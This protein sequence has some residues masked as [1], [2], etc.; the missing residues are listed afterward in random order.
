MS[1]RIGLG[2][3][4]GTVRAVVVRHRRIAWA[5]EAPLAGADEL[6]T[7]L[8]GLLALAPVPRWPRP[9]LH[10]AVGPHAAQLKRVV[11]LPEIADPDALAAIVREAAGTY[12]LRNGIPLITTGVQPAGAGSAVAGALERPCVDAIRA[13]CLA[14]GLRLG[15]IVPTAVALTRSLTDASF[16]WTDGRLTIEVQRAGPLIEAVRTRPTVPSDAEPLT[17]T[18]VADLAALGADSQ[19]YADAFGAA[20]LDAHEPVAIRSAAGLTT[21]VAGRRSL[22]QLAAVIAAGIIV[23]GLSPFA[24][25]WAGD[26]AQ[27]HVAQ[28]RPGRWKVITTAV[29]QLEKA[30]ALLRQASAF[31]A[32][33]AS[34]S[35]MLGDLA[36]TLPAQTALLQFD[37]S[38][39]RGELTALTTNPTAVVSAVRRVPGITRVE[40]VGTVTRLSAGGQDLQRITI[41]FARAER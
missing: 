15:P 26:R 41:R 1:T 5:G 39:D 20:T 7:A 2:I 34:L 9:T 10:V 18:P 17:L 6:Q 37:W 14:R 3:G 19:R 13:T 28:I 22:A 32:S 23:V 12:F 25:K 8:D 31:S 33:R 16:R 40:L 29:G 27:R 11:G 21:L 36:R 38:G 24:A 4:S 35:Q 30:N